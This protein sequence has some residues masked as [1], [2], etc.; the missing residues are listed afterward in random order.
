MTGGSD[1]LESPSVSSQ[2]TGAQPPQDNSSDC[3]L[4]NPAPSLNSC[5]AIP[6]LPL[7]GTPSAVG[8][9]HTHGPISSQLAT[10]TPLQNSYENGFCMMQIVQ[11]LLTP[12]EMNMNVKR[13]SC[14]SRWR[15]LNQPF[16][17]LKKNLQLHRCMRAP[18]AWVFSSVVP[19]RWREDL[20]LP[21]LNLVLFGIQFG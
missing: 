20:N 3:N 13:Q 16:S 18:S 4:E 19:R 8:A 21:T 5:F 10:W 12:N 15:G 6:H 11:T 17:A 9:L 14:S 1:Q 7:K 2:Q